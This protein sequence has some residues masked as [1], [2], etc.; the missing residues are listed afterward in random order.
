MAG[1]MVTAGLVTAGLPMRGR[2]V[3]YMLL[4][5]GAIVSSR[6]DQGWHPEC[7]E[8]LESITIQEAA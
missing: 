5:S 6:T 3:Q 1:Q 8:M 7:L 2:L 4:A